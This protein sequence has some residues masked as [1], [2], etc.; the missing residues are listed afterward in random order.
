M[1]NPRKTTTIPALGSTTIRE[2]TNVAWLSIISNSTL[3]TLKL[4]VGLAIGS[5]SVISEAIHSSTDL[6]AAFIALFAIK[7]SSKPAD[8]EHPF[9][10]QKFENLSG[11]AEA[12]LIFGAAVWIIYEAVHKLL[13]PAPLDN[14]GWGMAVML[15]SSL[16]NL[17][18]SQR[19][20]RT[21]KKTCS[22]ALE[23]DAW[24]LRTDVYT[25]AG[26]TLGLFLIAFGERLFPG[27]HF[28]WIDPVAAIA[29]ALLILKAA[30]TLTLKSTR[31]LLDESL[32]I[33]EEDL[34]RFHITGLAPVVRGFHRLKTRRAGHLRYV[35]FHMLVDAQMTVEQSHSIAD[36]VTDAIREHFPD[37]LLTI[38]IEPCKGYCDAD[39]SNDCLLSSDERIEIRKRYSKK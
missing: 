23:A 28:H 4:I 25:S 12:L 20:F 21:A 32:P 26:V 24:H 18:V 13:H 22:V 2:K 1:D 31:D 9:G 11:T 19:L 33:E 35:E 3:V 17:A 10:H 29:V 8:Q 27:T 14:P 38:H 30:Y 37:T 5:V 15:F 16:T 36:H 34:I 6:L 7:A 39:C